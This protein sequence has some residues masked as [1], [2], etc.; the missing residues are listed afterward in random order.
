MWQLFCWAPKSQNH[1]VEHLGVAG[2]LAVE[3]NTVFVGPPNWSVR[4]DRSIFCAPEA[5]RRA[6]GAA[7]REPPILC[8]TTTTTAIGASLHL[9]GIAWQALVA[10]L[11]GGVS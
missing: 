5:G 9:G 6:I 1:C 4:L 8:S 11:V 2:S 3:S 10:S 7:A